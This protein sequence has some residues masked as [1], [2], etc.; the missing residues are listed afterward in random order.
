MTE[1]HKEVLD[2]Y[3]FKGLA[4]LAAT[5][6]PSRFYLGGGSALGLRLGHRKSRDLD[7][8]DPAGLQD[9]P[10]LSARLTKVVPRF[11]VDEVSKGTIHAS[12]GKLKVSLLGYSYPLLEPS[13]SWPEGGVHI[14]SLNDLACMKLSAVVQRGLKR[15]FVDLWALAEHGEG[16]AGLLASYKKKY[17]VEDE[18]HILRAICYFDDAEKDPMPTM[19][20]KATWKSI[21]VYLARWVKN[22]V[23]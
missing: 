23:K 2:P 13:E 11:K 19:L 12:I 7:W 3:Q 8:F 10:G 15:D 22:F 14:A 18:A 1:F 20:R 6:E 17:K 9:A 5:L 21:K 4:S 16:L